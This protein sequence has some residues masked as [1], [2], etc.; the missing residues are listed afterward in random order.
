LTCL[1]Y[2][3]RHPFE[4][5]HP[6]LRIVRRFCSFFGYFGRVF[7]WFNVESNNIVTN[8]ASV[9]IFIGTAVLER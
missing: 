9:Y 6:A 5:K 7:S 3:R 8:A 1:Y 4:N 2:L